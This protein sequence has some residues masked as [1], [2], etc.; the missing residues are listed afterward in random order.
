L[1]RDES[2]SIP[3]EVK[4]ALTGAADIDLVGDIDKAMVGYFLDRLGE[5]TARGGNIV[6]AMTSS[7]GDPDLTRRIQLEVERTREEIAGRFLFLGKSVVYS[8]AVSVMAAFP[9]RDRYL[10]RDTVLLIHGRELDLSLELAGPLRLSR[11]RVEAVLGEIGLGMKLEEENFLRLIGDSGLGLE[12]V[13]EKAMRN[14]YLTAPE[15]QALGL[16]AGIV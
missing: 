12:E 16:V 15:A 6:L 9:C 1:R 7:G 5:A 10:T 14:W 8:A 13:V 3:E 11:P 4:A 2:P